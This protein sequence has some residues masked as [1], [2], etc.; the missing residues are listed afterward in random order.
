MSKEKGKSGTNNLLNQK[1][2]Q[3]CNHSL[4][5]LVERKVSIVKICQIFISKLS[6][7]SNLTNQMMIP[8]SGIM[9]MAASIECL[10]APLT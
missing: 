8:D 3:I 2:E 1:F 4:Y 6:A 7:I 9:E 10:Q 5:G